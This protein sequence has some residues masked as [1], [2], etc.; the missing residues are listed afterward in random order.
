MDLS[1]ESVGEGGWRFRSPS[2]E[3]P[4]NLLVLYEDDVRTMYD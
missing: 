4:E 1:W 3:T 2:P